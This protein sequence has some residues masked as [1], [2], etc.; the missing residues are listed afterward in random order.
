MEAHGEGRSSSTP[1]REWLAEPPCFLRGTRIRTDDADVPV[2]ALAPGTVVVTYGGGRQRVAWVGQRQLDLA[3]H[4]HPQRASPI[5]VRRG[6]I[7]NGVPERDL[8][9]SP[10]HALF[11]N[12]VLA[13]AHAMVNGATVLR[14]PSWQRLDYFHVALDAHAVLLAEGA[15]AESFPDRRVRAGFQ[16]GPVTVLHPAFADTPPA[17]SDCAPRVVHGPV[18]REVRRML[19]AR[20]FVLGHALTREPDLHLLVDG[21]RISASGVAGQLHRFPIP[22]GAVDVRIVCR[23]GVPAETEAASDDHRRL[24]VMLSRIVLRAGGLTIEIPAS[25]PGLCTGFHPPE[26]SAGGSWRWTDGHARLPSVPAGL[27]RVDLHVLGAQAAWARATPPGA[28]A[29]LGA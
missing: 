15:P 27:T 23:A 29:Q 19:L 3:R 9:V 28:P 1:S 2:E 14:D 21:T 7:S 17:P 11:L 26:R 18:V 24:G 13:P 12:Q 6:A 5:R 16:G 8:L 25:D 20:A 10:D 4:P 22:A